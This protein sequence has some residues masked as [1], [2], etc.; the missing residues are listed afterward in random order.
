MSN[1][2]DINTTQSKD[3]RVKAFYD[4]AMKELI[5]FYNVNWVNNTPVIYLVDSRNDFSVMA[6]YNTQ[7]W[8]VGKA[9]DHNKLLLLSPDSYEKDSSHKYSDNE[10]YSLIKHELSHFFFNILSNDEKPVWL[11]EGF[12]I[13]TSDQLS[14]KERPKVLKNFLRYYSYEDKDVYSESGFVVEGLINKYGKDK[15]LDFLKLLPNVNS[16]DDFKREFE[17]YFEMKLEYGSVGKL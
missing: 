10:Y 7:D 11:N 12:A 5:S 6:G 17:K 14:K 9:F 1:I 13:Y 3:K 2:Y 15:V 16:E 8:E 4:K